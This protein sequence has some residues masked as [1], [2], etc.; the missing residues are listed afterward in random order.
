[1]GVIETR[2]GSF[3]PA[4][5]A[6]LARMEWMARR[7]RY[8]EAAEVLLRWVYAYR[9]GGTAW[10]AFPEE[11]RVAARENGPSVVAD[12]RSTIGSYPRR[13]DLATITVPV[14]CTLGSRSGDYMR[15]IQRSLRAVI[16]AARLSEI[17]GAAHPVP[18]HAPP[19]F[20][21]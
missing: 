5:I 21:E 10:D 16:P 8:A 17:E 4:G 13:S 2:T 12:L 1:M 18:S 6:T 11:W 14:V 20:V 15:A 3:D 19:A 9:D 7:A